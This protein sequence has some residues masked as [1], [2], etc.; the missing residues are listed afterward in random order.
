[1]TQPDASLVFRQ[2][3]DADVD[4]AVDILNAA[5]EW[6]IARGIRQWTTTYP[7][8]LYQ[9]AQEQGENFGLFEDDRLVAIVTVTSAPPE[10]QAELSGHDVRW[11]TKLAVAAD[12]HGRGLG[13]R[14]AKETLE[15]L[16]RAGA[17]G[18][19]LDCRNGPL[20]AFYQSLGFERIT[21][22]VVHFA[23]GPLDVVLMKRELEGGSAPGVG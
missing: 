4:P 22:K 11:I 5:A 8:E 9:R 19:W 12:R 13:R 1:L 6:L 18:A 10:W 21:N 14:L 16:R 2:L 15:Q 20:V 17:P 23:T 3:S 7:R